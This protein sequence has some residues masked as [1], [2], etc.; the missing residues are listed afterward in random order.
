VRQKN[1][2]KKI[3]AEK[4]WQ[5]MCG[6]KIAAEKSWQ[7]HGWGIFMRDMAYLV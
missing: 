3:A 6:K 7:Q 2:Y 4:M 1:H 5:K